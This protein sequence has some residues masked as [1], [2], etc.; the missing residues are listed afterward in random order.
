MIVPSLNFPHGLLPGRKSYPLNLATSKNAIL[1]SCRHWSLDHAPSQRI[2]DRSIKF[3][4]FAGL[5]AF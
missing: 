1:T 4:A 5:L 2:I 3:V